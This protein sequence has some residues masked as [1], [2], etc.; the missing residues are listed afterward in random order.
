M[1]EA[2]PNAGSAP[3]EVEELFKENQALLGV[4]YAALTY[5]R[6]LTNDNQKALIAEVDAAVASLRTCKDGGSNG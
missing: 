4:F 5:R 3:S 1:L 2:S 6:L